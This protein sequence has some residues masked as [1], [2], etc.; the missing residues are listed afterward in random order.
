MPQAS[1]PD[2]SSV[3][4]FTAIFSS[5]RPGWRRAHGCSALSLT[6][7]LSIANGVKVVRNALRRAQHDL[8]C[9]HPDLAGKA[10]IADEITDASSASRRVPDLALGEIAKIAG[11]RLRELIPG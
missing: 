11:F 9:A 6:R 1:N 2:A 5:I 4:K 3:L 10:A 8:N 7:M